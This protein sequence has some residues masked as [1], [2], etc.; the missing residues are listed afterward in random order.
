MADRT[1]LNW[2]ESRSKKEDGE[3][4]EMILSPVF[5]FLLFVWFIQGGKL[6]IN[7][8]HEAVQGFVQ[9][10]SSCFPSLP[11]Y[12]HLSW[13]GFNLTLAHLLPGKMH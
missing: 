1:L 3:Q 6:T 5:F 8:T 11:W 10:H 12:Y 13:A 9:H 4:V 2:E 7:D